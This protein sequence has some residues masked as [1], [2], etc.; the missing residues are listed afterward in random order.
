M[1]KKSKAQSTTVKDLL[2]QVKNRVDHHLNVLQDECDQVQDKMEVLERV[3][4]QIDEA[5]DSLATTDLE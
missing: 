4:E 2:M 3:L 5:V 1:A